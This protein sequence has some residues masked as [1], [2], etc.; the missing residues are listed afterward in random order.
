MAASLRRSAAR[1][2]QPMKLRDFPDVAAA[3]AKYRSLKDRRQAILDEIA[4]IERQIRDLL[5]VDDTDAIQARAQAVV[6]GE[7]I[8]GGAAMVNLTARLR[9]LQGHLAIWER[10]VAIQ[11]ATVGDLE[12]S[13]SVELAD[14]FRPRH[15]DAVAGL[16]RAFEALKAAVA[17]ERAVRS[18]LADTGAHPL[19]P[20]F[21]DLGARLR[22]IESEYTAAD[23]LR[24][25]AE[26]SR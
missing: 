14:A 1:A 6:D 25:A 8:P 18:D 3:D 24:R 17:S 13:R 21:D 11:K 2:A 20:A 26:Y 16:V 19:L 4:E 10:A 15:K 9:E 22:Q 23:F 7:D 12:H 5:L